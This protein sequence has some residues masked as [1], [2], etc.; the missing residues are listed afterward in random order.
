MNQLRVHKEEADIDK[1]DIP[2]SILYTARGKLLMDEE[3]SR[4][5]PLERFSDQRVVDAS[6]HIVDKHSN[7]FPY[8]RILLQ[9]VG[10]WERSRNVRRGEES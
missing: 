2:P 4:V 10:S 6:R 1:G 3:K 5:G 7:M 8:E 9:N